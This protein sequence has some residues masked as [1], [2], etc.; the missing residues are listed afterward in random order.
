MFSFKMKSI[1]NST[2]FEYLF[3]NFDSNIKISLF[4][5]LNLY[6]MNKDYVLMT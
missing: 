3:N 2:L 5:T 1:A 6:Y 4:E